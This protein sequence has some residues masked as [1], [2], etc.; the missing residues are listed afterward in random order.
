MGV[1]I[2]E[3]KQHRNIAK[4]KRSILEMPVLKESGFN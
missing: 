3:I 2:L 4:L 1:F